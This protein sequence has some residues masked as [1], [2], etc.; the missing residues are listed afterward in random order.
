[1]RMGG[2]DPKNWSGQIG[3][4]GNRLSQKSGTLT[5]TLHPP[6][7]KTEEGV[8][9]LLLGRMALILPPC[10]HNR[11]RLKEI[12]ATA[13]DKT[14]AKFSLNY[15][16]AGDPPKKKER[17]GMTSRRLRNGMFS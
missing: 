3:C 12:E 11:L 15:E 4:S 7:H 17:P 5:P 1:M 8:L 14:A 10:F 2:S 6:R 13:L 9:E 16:L